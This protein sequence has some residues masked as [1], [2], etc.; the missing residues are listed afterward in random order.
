[1]TKLMSRRTAIKTGGIA[2]LGSLLTP[3]IAL[4]NENKIALDQAPSPTC[5][6]TVETPS[7][8]TIFRSEEPGES[9]IGQDAKGNDY[10]I[11]RKTS[12]T[13]NGNETVSSSCRTELIRSSA[14]QG[15]SVGSVTEND[16]IYAYVQIEVTY[17]LSGESIKVPKAV[18]TVRSRAS[19]AS[20]QH[21]SMTASQGIIGSFC[22]E[23]VFTTESHTIT[24]G[25]PYCPYQPTLNS[26]YMH[27]NGGECIGQFYVSGM[28]EQII[29][30]EW[31]I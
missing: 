21:R 5:I 24:T 31:T 20:V 4:G 3:S 1:M 17:S 23:A 10:T 11:R 14:N 26:M 30:A 12:I 7:G 9:S 19:Y 27:L 22:K 18:G 15:R 16:E 8:K 2:M 28:G 25:W 13:Q 29:H 6:F